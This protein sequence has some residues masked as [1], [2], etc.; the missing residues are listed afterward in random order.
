MRTDLIDIS[1][2]LAAE[3]FQIFVLAGAVEGAL[4]LPAQQRIEFERQ[5]ARL[6]RPILKETALALAEGALVER[7]VTIVTGAREYRKVVRAHQHIDAVDLQKVHFGDRVFDARPV[8]GAVALAP[9]EA[10]RD[11]SDTT[12]LQVRK[13]VGF[14][15]LKTLRILTR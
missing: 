2:L 11:Q 15:H 12:R 5:E 4:H 13:C 14:A 3:F 7:L 10:L 8:G 1:F 6:V 9:G